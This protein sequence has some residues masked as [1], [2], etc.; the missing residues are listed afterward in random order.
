M[1]RRLLLSVRLMSLIASAVAALVRFNERGMAGYRRGG[2][3]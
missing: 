1:D 2:S 3:K